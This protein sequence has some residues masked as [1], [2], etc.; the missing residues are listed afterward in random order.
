MD[1]S[2]NTEKQ[3][4]DHLMHAIAN[5]SCIPVVGAGASMPVGAPNWDQFIELL[6]DRLPSELQALAR[7]RED[8]TEVAATL[9]W[10]RRMR[11][12]PDVPIPEGP[13]SHIH[14]I[15][16]SWNCPL[17]LT[18]NY[19]QR[20]E[21]AVKAV[22]PRSIVLLND[23]LTTLSV[24]AVMSQRLPA[25]CVVKLCSSTSKHNPGYSTHVDFA[26]LIYHHAALE[27]LLTL[28]R[29]YT[30]VF[31]G[32]SLRDKLIEA[33][34][35]RACAS[36]LGYG[37]HI[38]LQFDTF[39][40]AHERAL[41]DLHVDVIRIGPPTEPTRLPALLGTY[42]SGRPISRTSVL[43]FEPGS[44]TK[45]LLALA[46]A[47]NIPE[48]GRLEF[49]TSDN[50][51]HNALS[52]LQPQSV[53][54]PQVRCHL[55]SDVHNTSK[56]HQSLA[57][58]ANIDWNAVV[59]VYEFAVEAAASYA[60]ECGLPLSH[61][62]TGVARLCRDKR[63]FR[64]FVQDRFGA[65]SLIYPI[66]YTTISYTA[67][68]TATEF[69]REL[70]AA[71]LQLPTNDGQYVIKPPDAAASIGVRPL[72]FSNN[73]AL[74]SSI[75]DLLRIVLSMP[76]QLETARCTTDAL[77][78]ERRIFAE[79]FSVESR[80]TGPDQDEVL[81]IHWK[82]DIDADSMR[83]FERL[84]VTLP[85]NTKVHAEI[86]KA[87]SALLKEL[88]TVGLS[89]GVFHGEFRY[90]VSNNRAY[91][92]EIGLR[93]GGGMVPLSVKAS[94]GVDLYEASLRAAL[95]LAQK[96]IQ[97]E[98][99]IG[100]GL[101]FAK[102]PGVLNL[103]RVGDKR[104]TEPVALSHA[105]DGLL[106]DILNANLKRIDRA[107]LRDSVLKQALFP[108]ESTRDRPDASS[109]LRQQVMA[110]F[111]ADFLGSL[112]HVE[113]VETWIKPGE[114]VKETEATYVGGILVSV[115]EELE[116][117]SAVAEAVAAVEY[118]L[119]IVQCDVEPH[120]RLDWRETRSSWHEWHRQLSRT[121]FRSDPDSWT[122]SKGIELACHGN[123]TAS[124]LDLGCGSSLPALNSIKD[125]VG[126]TGID[127]NEAALVTATANLTRAS[128]GSFRLIRGDVTCQSDWLNQMPKEVNIV[129]AN[130]PYLPA[131][132]GILGIEV[133]GGI[134]GLRLIP[135]TV[136]DIAESL[137]SST[138][139][140]NVASLCAL[141]VLADRLEMRGYG[142][143]GLVAAIAPLEQYAL[144]T[145]SYLESL[146]Q[147]RFLRF[148][149][150]SEKKQI[151]YSLVLRKNAPLPAQSALSQAQE[152]IVRM[153]AEGRVLIGYTYGQDVVA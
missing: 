77:I 152:L 76:F 14:R 141:D 61:H 105:D 27:L 50:S 137:H 37:R 125:G 15:L 45:A 148:V 20:L 58:V 113:L 59:S 115:N 46:A 49:L 43:I 60:N 108:S 41:N 67:G 8:R 38:A 86:R 146:P 149:E 84:F 116:G 117:F 134:D 7:S 13:P 25:P 73:R 78:I 145:L 30:L 94:T 69:S 151:I 150:Q 47:R 132:P 33:A 23:Q 147:G 40:T 28:L 1:D 55:I 51:V 140:L 107:Y 89:T 111:S 52:G 119:E 114:P 130:L 31:V 12:L 72:D 153:P 4:T 131:L 88:G 17:Y 82:V 24:S 120:V 79:E 39:G 93:P 143:V 109:A 53:L 34:L 5:R 87:N 16:A 135:D 96:T 90:D 6:A 142:V 56:V 68:T 123:R 54:A 138:V 139:V 106:R 129:A 102:T 110:A 36:R 11:R 91:P 26:E 127:I 19:D 133:D 48:L 57:S 74:Q 62:S 80:R 42:G 144:Q 18:T 128:P 118:C 122:F 9:I 2:P 29:T 83:F 100:T 75:D 10:E 65:S 99:V 21:S 44:V 98:R 22:D 112:A 121:A 70:E 81:A 63:D 66:E 95:N 35:D 71:I 92:L 101:I 64:K 124:L 103:L 104:Y 126:Y 32:C 136:L 3:A 97:H 85:R